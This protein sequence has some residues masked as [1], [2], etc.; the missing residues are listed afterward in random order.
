MLHHA[1]RLWLAYIGK[2]L[3]ENGLDPDL[4]D[5][6]DNEY[7]LMDEGDAEHEIE[8]LQTSYTARLPFT[9]VMVWLIRVLY[10]F[11]RLRRPWWKL[12]GVGNPVVDDS[13]HRALSIPSSPQSHRKNAHR[14]IVCSFSSDAF[15]FPSDFADLHFGGAKRPYC[16]RGMALLGPLWG[17]T[18]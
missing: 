10:Q 17:S 11:R 3:L 18:Q 12:C 7:G 9:S 5:D 2:K 13:F 14:Y 6:K 16:D 8:H 15:F 4:S 1:A